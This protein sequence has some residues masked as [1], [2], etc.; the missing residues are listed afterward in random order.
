M[1]ELLPHRRS[2]RISGYDYTTP[3][4]YFIT[5][6]SLY[7][8]PYFGRLEGENCNPSS[9]GEIILDC[10]VMIPQHFPNARC[11]AFMLMPDHFHGIV[12]LTTKSINGHEFE[13]GHD[14]SCPY[15]GGQQDINQEAFARPVSGSVPTIIRTFKAA[16]TRKV[17]KPVWQRGYYEHILRDYEDLDR[18]R[19]YIETQYL[20][21]T[22]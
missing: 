7:R 15:G 4:Y 16:V 17:G 5:I 1:V 9:I 8:E 20:R 11:D 21:A 13:Y 18:V 10:W 19:G 6:N 3:G 22:K 14:I 2:I 12:E